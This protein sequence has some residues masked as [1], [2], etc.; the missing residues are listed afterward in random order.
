MDH[1]QNAIRQFYGIRI[2]RGEIKG[3]FQPEQPTLASSDTIHV[4]MLEQIYR[5]KQHYD[6]KLLSED[7]PYKS[8]DP[9]YD[10]NEVDEAY[11]DEDEYDEDEDEDEDDDDDEDGDE[12]G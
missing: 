9:E 12:G 2:S 1:F 4:E 8:Y 5:G 10:E 7:I 11:A 3:K 6:R